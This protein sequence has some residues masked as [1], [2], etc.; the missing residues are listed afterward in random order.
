MLKE[1]IKNGIRILFDPEKEF[2]LLNKRSLEPVVWDYAIVLAAS[3][4]MAGIFNLFFSIAKAFYFDLLVDIS[5]QYPRMI[6]YS[7]GRSTSIIFLY[8]FAG[9]FLLFFLSLLLRLVFRNMKYTSLLKI[10]MYS[11]MPMLLFGW[12]LANPFPLAIWSIFLIYT[13]VKNHK[14]MKIRKDSIEMRE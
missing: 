1:P 8:L 3:A 9:T 11:G 13:G 7:I 10:L 4:I 14:Y 2:S 5:I 12:F 6:N